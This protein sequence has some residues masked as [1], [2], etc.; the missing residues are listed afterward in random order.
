MDS[1]RRQALTRHLYVAALLLPV[2]C[3]DILNMCVRWVYM[4]SICASLRP[5][6]QKIDLQPRGLVLL[7]LPPM[8]SRTCAQGRVKCEVGKNTTVHAPHR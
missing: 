3:A 6:T 8:G 2:C 4:A 7:I 1:S 5:V